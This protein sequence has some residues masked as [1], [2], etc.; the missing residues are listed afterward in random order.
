ML[1]EAPV[2]RKGIPGK[3]ATVYDTPL[4]RF[5][6]ANN[7]SP[8]RLAGEAQIPR[9]ALRLYRARVQEPTRPVM[10]R[11]VL[12]LRIITGK[13]VR[14]SDLWYLGELEQ[15]EWEVKDRSIRAAKPKYFTGHE[16]KGPKR[17]S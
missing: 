3:R 14:A 1:R 9:Q 8:S 17:T 4:D 11:I 10:A 5:I 16:P 7:V 12:G 13:N 2:F 6:Q 15:D